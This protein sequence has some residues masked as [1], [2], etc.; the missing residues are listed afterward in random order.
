[1]PLNPIVNPAPNDGGA[2]SLYTVGNKINQNNT[3]LEGKID[4]E[5][6]DRAAHEADT[7]NP[8]SVTATQVGLGNCMIRSRQNDRSCQ[9]RGR[10]ILSGLSFDKI[11]LLR[12]LLRAF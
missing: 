8:H 4:Q 9:E 2:D 12:L 3:Y 10:H 6:T 11:I 5:I 7:A 1:M